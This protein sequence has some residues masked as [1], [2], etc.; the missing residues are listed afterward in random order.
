[1]PIVDFNS[2]LHNRKCSSCLFLPV[3]MNFHTTVRIFFHLLQAGSRNDTGGNPE[4]KFLRLK[5]PKNTREFQLLLERLER[6]PT[7]AHKAKAALA[8]HGFEVS[9]MI[10]KISF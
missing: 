2:D 10:A 5:Y 3:D 6:A 9:I 7:A 1:M 8:F 4:R